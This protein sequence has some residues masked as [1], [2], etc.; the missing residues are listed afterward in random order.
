MP[1]RVT[2]SSPGLAASATLGK[3]VYLALN[4]NA[5][6]VCHRFWLRGEILVNGT[7]RASRSMRARD[8]RAPLALLPRV[9]QGDRYQQRSAGLAGYSVDGLWGRTALGELPAIG[10]AGQ[11]FFLRPLT[12]GSVD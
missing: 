4:R 11:L 7:V 1:Q 10:G 5:V 2:A 3:W 6:A 8:A 12:P 9:A